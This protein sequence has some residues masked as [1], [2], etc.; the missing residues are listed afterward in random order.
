[1]LGDIA[2]AVLSGLGRRSPHP[3]IG[4]KCPFLVND[5]AYFFG[6]MMGSEV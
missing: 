6:S 2:L 4:F 1:M 5:P 3:K